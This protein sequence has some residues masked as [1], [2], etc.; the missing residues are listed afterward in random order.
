MPPFYLLTPQDNTLFAG[1]IQGAV[2]WTVDPER[3]K[4]FPTHLRATLA[5]QELDRLYG[6]CGFY[7]LQIIDQTRLAELYP[8][9]ERP[10]A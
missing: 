9:N 7:T 3:A 8:S 4:P 1:L 5:N 10:T 2:E 6:E